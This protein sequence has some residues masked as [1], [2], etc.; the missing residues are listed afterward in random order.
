MNHL[1]MLFKRVISCWF[2]LQKS[3]GFGRRLVLP[4]ENH[5]GHSFTLRDRQKRPRDFVM[6]RMRTLPPIVFEL[7]GPWGAQVSLLEENLNTLSCL[8]LS[9]LLRGRWHSPGDSIMNNE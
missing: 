8:K 3:P 1:Y 5:P 2:S 4:S 7:V 6:K 9:G